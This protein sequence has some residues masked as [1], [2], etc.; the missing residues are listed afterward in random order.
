M[1]RVDF[2]STVLDAKA[3]IRE[4]KVKFLVGI[5]VIVIGGVLGVVSALNFNEVTRVYLLRFNVFL[6]LTGDRGFGGYFLVRWLLLLAMVLAMSLVGIRPLTCWLA[7]IFVFIFAYQ[8]LLFVTLMFIYGAVRVLPLMLL[9]VIPFMLIAFFI[10]TF[11]MA[12]V[13]CLAK[14]SPILRINDCKCYFKSVGLKF[15]FCAIIFAVFAVLETAFVFL[16]SI[17]IAY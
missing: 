1:L 10:L 2:N 7:P 15:L 13:F 3:F 16:L 4:N 17:G 11:Y 8:A 12:F 9:G 5:V 6:V 14:N